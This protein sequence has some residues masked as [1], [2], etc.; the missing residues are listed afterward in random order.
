M[1]KCFYFWQS[2]LQGISL[3]ISYDSDIDHL[4][5]SAVS[6]EIS[7]SLMTLIYC[8]FYELLNTYKSFNWVRILA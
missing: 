6:V 1:V 3:T 2:D 7:T 5:D 4:L 8:F